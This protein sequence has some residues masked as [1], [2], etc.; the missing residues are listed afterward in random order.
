[1][2]DDGKV[3]TV[4]Y[5]KTIHKVK[6]INLKFK[7]KL[8]LW[9]AYR[10]TFYAIEFRRCYY[11]CVHQVAMTLNVF[12]DSSNLWFIRFFFFKNKIIKNIYD[13][14]TN[15]EKEYYS[16]GNSS[17]SERLREITHKSSQHW[18]NSRSKFDELSKIKKNNKTS[19][20]ISL[21][22]AMETFLNYKKWEFHYHMGTRT[23]THQN[24]LILIE[25][26]FILKDD[27]KN[28]VGIGKRCLLNIETVI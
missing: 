21:C 7:L 3:R 2:V 27:D 26:N 12:I 5:V 10:H 22:D 13:K 17:H 23:N 14:N 19:K 25:I 6:S 20:R 24:I 16:S 4:S 18:E 1:M 15:M 11:R 9:F 28:K 8:L